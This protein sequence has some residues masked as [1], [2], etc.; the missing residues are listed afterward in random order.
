MWRWS[1]A[2]G[3]WLMEGSYLPQLWRLH[4]VKEAE[5]ISLLFPAM[6]LAGR[7]LVFAYTAF[8]GEGILALGFVCGLILRATFLLQTLYYRRRRRWLEELR[9]TTL[10]L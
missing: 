2:V 9:N 1:A 3:M 8:R 4:R 10:G 6:N 7:T 5:E